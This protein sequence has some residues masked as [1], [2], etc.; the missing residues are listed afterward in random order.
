[1]GVIFFFSFPHVLQLLQLR[2]TQQNLCFV[3]D[4]MMM[5][6]LTPGR[7]PYFPQILYC[8]RKCL[9]VNFLTK[10]TSLPIVFTIGCGVI[11]KIRKQ[12]PIFFKHVYSW[13]LCF[14]SYQ[15]TN[16]THIGAIL[17]KVTRITPGYL[18]P[19]MFIIS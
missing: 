15:T 18:M 4:W 11:S 16:L 8:N 10:Y 9:F 12:S 2:F 14:D 3:N 7:K 1:M 5:H 17:R 6:Q 19:Q 13:W